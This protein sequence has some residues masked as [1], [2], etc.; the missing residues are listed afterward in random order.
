[1]KRLSF[2][3]VPLLLL[4]LEGTMF[5]GAPRGR[6]NLF[7]V[8][9]DGTPLTGSQTIA[10]TPH[11]CDADCNNC[12]QLADGE[13]ETTS[14]EDGLMSFT[15]APG[16]MDYSLY[17][18]ATTLVCLQLTLNGEEMDK[19]IP[20]NA[21]SYAVRAKSAL[22]ADLINPDF[23]QNVANIL[24]GT[25]T[26]WTGPQTFEYLSLPSRIVTS[27][28]TV[29][30]SDTLV[31]ADAANGSFTI[32]LP[33]AAAVPGKFMIIKRV[34]DGSGSKGGGNTVTVSG[35]SDTFDGTTT[36][37]FTMA[38]GTSYELVSLGRAGWVVTS[39][40]TSAP[41][42]GTSSFDRTKKDDPGTATTTTPPSK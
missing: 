17:D 26:V 14:A 1:M 38:S 40:T 25:T 6:F 37:S 24:A 35:G 28:T 36:T 9:R 21:N 16:V 42:G 22:E 12:T 30:A 4:A 11:N 7:A 27:A 13:S 3:L 34:V 29:A 31:V 23:A 33:S 15:V 39:A 19:K 8:E 41:I 32:T 5:A 20:L 10:V 18:D 2:L